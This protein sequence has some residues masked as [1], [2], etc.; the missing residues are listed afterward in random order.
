MSAYELT[1]VMPAFN[2]EAGIEA[3]VNEVRAE[4]LDKIPATLLVVEDGSRDRTNEILDRLEQEDDRVRAHHKEN[5]G[6]GPALIRGVELADTPWILLI[7]SDMQIPL[8]GF[9]EIW[10]R[11]QGLDG[12]F[13]VRA[14]RDD[15]RFR[16]FLTGVIRFALRLL[17]RCKLRDANVPF[18]LF[19]RED[20]NRARAIIPHDTL[21]PSLFYAVV[22]ARRGQHIE[23]LELPHRERQTGVV[24][25]RRW[26]L[27]KFCWRAF[28]Q[29]LQFRRR[30]RD[31]L[32][33][34]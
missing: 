5:E 18:K 19:R 10:T 1:V 11:A 2:E 4:I 9:A 14:K 7:D 29:L 20:W 3:A 21:A 27:V 13:G 28:L 6:H 31:H 12:I 15:P 8:Q 24:S 22:A 34:R 23:H 16:L 26:K 33:G 30:L 17:L 32:Q 25:I